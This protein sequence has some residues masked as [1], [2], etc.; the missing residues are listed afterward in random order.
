MA[1]PKKYETFKKFPGVRAYLSETRKTPDGKP[2]KCFYI[3]YKNLNGKLIEEKI[4]WASEGITAAYAAQIRAERLRTVR[5]GEE[6]IPIH[7]KRKEAVTFAQFMRKRYL[8]WAKENKAWESYRREEEL[9]RRYIDPVI[10]DKT[11]KD[12]SPFDLER[13]KSDMRKKGLAERTTEYALAVVRM[14]FNRAK[15]WGLFRGDNPASK[16]KPPRK[17]NRRLRFLTPEEASLLLEAVKKR[18]RQ[19]YEI[20]L[21][22]LHTGMRA[23]E[24]FNLTWADIDMARGLIYIRDPKNN[25]TRVAY[26]T[27]E[28]KRLFMAKTP[29]EPSEL[30]FKDRKGQKIKKVSRV[31]WEV[32]QEL[33]FNEGVADHRMRVCFHTLRHTFASWLVMN[34]TPLFTVKEL[35]GHKT[36][37]MT[38]RY[39]HLAAEAQ[40]QAIKEIERVAL[41]AMTGKVVS[42]TEKLGG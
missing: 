6:P 38:E 15:E 18:S 40:R 31:F 23:G 39:A 36:M 22:S 4:G 7:K 41:Q 8:P 19:L 37:L 35:L 16:V 29:G 27:D 13:I 14:A 42:Y 1:K 20:C 34:G 33:G 26:M 3:R 24:I 5:L 28:V 17:D 12:I 30:V 25:T 2:D 21:L 9:F 32:V 10:G 11:L